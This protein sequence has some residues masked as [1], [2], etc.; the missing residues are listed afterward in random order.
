MSNLDLSILVK[1]IHLI[2][3]DCLPVRTLRQLQALQFPGEPRVEFWT[4]SQ[5]NPRKITCVHC[6]GDFWSG[7][8]A[9]KEIVDR[10]EARLGEG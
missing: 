4:A 3:Y 6:W 5:E 7:Y 2:G 8:R 10:T 9:A 1:G